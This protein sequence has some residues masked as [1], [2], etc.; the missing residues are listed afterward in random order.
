MGRVTRATHATAADTPPPGRRRRSTSADPFRKVT[1]RL[2]ER[3]ATAIRD[4]VNTGAAPSTDAFIEEAVVARFRELR[5]DRMYA[6]YAKA[7]ADPVFMAE[8]EATNRL[9]DR[10]VAD[11]LGVGPRKGAR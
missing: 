9:F 8:M 1:L 6:A 10:A 3:V 5:R 11:G 4:L 7:T 2:H